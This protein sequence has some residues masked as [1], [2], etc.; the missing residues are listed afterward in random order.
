MIVLLKMRLMNMTEIVENN[1]AADI[2]WHEVDGSHLRSNITFVGQENFSYVYSEQKSDLKAIHIYCRFLDE[3]L[4]LIVNET[5]RNA[6]QTINKQT[7][8]RKARINQWKPTNTEEITKFLG[9]I[10]FQLLLRYIHFAD[11]LT[12]EPGDRLHKLRDIF[13]LVQEKFT[14]EVVTID[15]TLVPFRE[16]FLFRQY[17]PNK[18]HRYG[19]KIFKL[20][21]PVGY[22]LKMNIYTG[23]K[24][25]NASHGKGLAQRIVETLSEQYLNE[26]RTIITDNF[27]T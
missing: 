25:P 12:A 7:H 24:D 1:D 5:N 2:F 16:R 19:L 18:R 20:C 13:T 17:I 26:G 11:N 14:N 15:E 9:L 21:N 3:V 8:T 22:T 10:I 27:Y 6:E 4:T 23:Q